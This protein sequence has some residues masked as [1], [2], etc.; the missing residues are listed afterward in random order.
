MNDAQKFENFGCIKISNFIDPESI[1]IISNYFENKINRGEWKEGYEGRNA[2]TKYFY[3]ADPLIEVLLLKSKDAV[4]KIVGKKLL[5]TYSYSR[6]YQPGEELTPHV[7]RNSCE[8]TVTVNVANKGENS[9]IFM[10]YGSKESGEYILNP[11]DAVIYKGCEV[12]H[13]RNVLKD[14]QLTVQFM[15][16]YVDEN[17]PNFKFAKDRRPKYGLNTV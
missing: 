13:W 6:I 4:E 8:I 17:G 9:P 10:K 7:D 3:Y 1:S 11:G 5:P 16:H 12:K 2:S 15:L 14:D